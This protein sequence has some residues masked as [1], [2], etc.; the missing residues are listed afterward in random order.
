MGA[1]KRN[2]EACHWGWGTH[3]TG[4]SWGS[5][6]GGKKRVRDIALHY[7]QGISKAKLSVPEERRAG[8]CNHG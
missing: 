8:D 4:R 1:E 5:D 7:F 2:K 3:P 6:A